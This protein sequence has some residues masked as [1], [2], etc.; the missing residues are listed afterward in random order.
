MR[1]TVR[2]ARRNRAGR[3]ERPDDAI[4]AAVQRGLAAWGLLATARAKELVLSGPKTGKVYGNHQASAPGE[5]PASDTGR[6]VSSIRWEF[7]GSRLAIRVIAGTEY[8]AYLEFGTSIMLPRPFLR[9][10][11]LETEAQGRKLIDA[12]VYKAF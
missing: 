11:I 10:A 5:P 2:T 1:F 8:A 7:T 3:F 4:K 9:R 12:E 6:L